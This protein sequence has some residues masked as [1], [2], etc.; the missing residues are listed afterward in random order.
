MHL[1]E[2]RFRMLCKLFPILFPVPL[3]EQTETQGS[4]ND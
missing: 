3:A 4:L 2:M 1:P